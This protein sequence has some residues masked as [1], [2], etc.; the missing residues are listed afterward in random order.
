MREGC[1]ASS[2]LREF[3][4]GGRRKV[5]AW[6]MRPGFHRTMRA[7][8]A[9][10]EGKLRP[11]PA[12]SGLEEQEMARVN[13]QPSAPHTSLLGPTQAPSG[14]PDFV[15]HIS[16]SNGGQACNELT[17]PSIET[18]DLKHSLKR[19]W[20]CTAYISPLSAKC[21]N[22]CVTQHRT[23]LQAWKGAVSAVLEAGRQSQWLSRWRHKATKRVQCNLARGTNITKDW[24]LGEGGMLTF[25][26]KSDLTMV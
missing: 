2:A 3:A 5:Q 19:L 9:R 4:T 20:D 11:C 24:L 12:S 7:K 10:P 23:I 18:L 17:W 6:R 21:Y 1:R 8:H 22:D 14:F 16:A 25:K 13:A 26:N 15:Q